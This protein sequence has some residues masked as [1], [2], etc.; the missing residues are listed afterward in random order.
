MI[1][2]QSCS[3]ASPVL[4]VALGR[5]WQGCRGVRAVDAGTLAVV[6]SPPLS[7]SRLRRGTS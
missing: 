4:T 2:L 7:C 5:Q 3:D 1:C 6:L